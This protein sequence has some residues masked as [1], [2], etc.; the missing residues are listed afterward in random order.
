MAADGDERLAYRGVF[1]RL[2]HPTRDR[3]HH[4]RDRRSGSSSG[5][6]PV[7]FGTANGTAGLLDVAATL[8]IMAVAVSMLMIGG[9]FDLSSGCDDRRDGHPHHP[10]GQGDRR[11]R[12]RRPQPLDRHSDLVR[13]RA[14]AS[15]ASTARWSNERRCRASSSRSAR[16]SCL[17]GAKLGFSKLIVDQIQVGRTDEGHGY[18]FW[19]PI[20]AGEW[21]RTL[22]HVGGSRH[23]LHRRG[24]RSASPD[25]ARRVRDALHRASAWPQPRRPDPV[26]RRRRH[27]RRRRRSCSTSPTASVAT[28]SALR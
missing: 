12:R 23:R 20:F 17:K 13:R 19:Q 28:G 22:H 1:Q 14:R 7:P 11:P 2:L 9:E 16:S 24:A 8:G 27:R 26:R 15:A 4:R 5:P 6:C 25:P 21:D 18:D 3:R 10:A